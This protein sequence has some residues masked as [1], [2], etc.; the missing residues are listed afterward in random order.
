M[1]N[2]SSRKK[3]QSGSSIPTHVH[4]KIRMD[5]DNV[6][7]TEKIK[8]NMWRPQ[9]YDDFF[10]ELRYFRGFAQLQDMIDQAIISV[11]V[12]EN[13]TLP[14]VTTNQFPFPCHTQDL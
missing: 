3:R 12:G 13:V 2:E 6:P 14:S 7:D 5:V 4:Y 10:T 8:A 11:H 1:P 9:P